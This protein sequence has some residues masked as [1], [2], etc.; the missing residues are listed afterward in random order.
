M[1]VDE[2]A[3]GAKMPSEAAVVLDINDLL[4]IICLIYEIKWQV[5]AD[6]ISNV[7]I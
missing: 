4:S 7:K 1:F 5:A 6:L 3:A 2:N